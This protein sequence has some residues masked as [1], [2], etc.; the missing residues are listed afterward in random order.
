MPLV[1]LV[2]EGGC[3][4]GGPGPRVVCRSAGGWPLYALSLGPRLRLSPAAAPGLGPCQ[5]PQRR[6]MTQAIRVF[7]FQIVG[8][9]VKRQIFKSYQAFPK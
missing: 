7:S 6:G 4:R 3:G 8:S 1:R 2:V 9:F 5:S